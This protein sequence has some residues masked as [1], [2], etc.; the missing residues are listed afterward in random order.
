MIGMAIAA[1][2]ISATPASAG[3]TTTTLKVANFTRSKCSVPHTPVIHSP[4]TVRYSHARA[5]V[6]PTVIT[7]SLEVE[8]PPSHALTF[9]WVWWP[10]NR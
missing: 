8:S 7:P 4:V 10:F 3:L 1:A 5:Q 9:G 6:P 2:L